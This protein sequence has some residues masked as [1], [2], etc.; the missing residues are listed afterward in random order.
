MFHVLDLI[1]RVI[2]MQNTQ[3]QCDRYAKLPYSGA[4]CIV[5]LKYGSSWELSKRLIK[6]YARFK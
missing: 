1:E 3:K 5:E 4:N 2:D 6:S